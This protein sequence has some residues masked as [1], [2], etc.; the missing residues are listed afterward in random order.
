MFD[1]DVISG[2]T[3]AELRRMQREAQRRPEPGKAAPV[4]GTEQR[5]PEAK[6]DEGRVTAPR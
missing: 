3:P 4:A 1:F 2:P 6:E 5:G